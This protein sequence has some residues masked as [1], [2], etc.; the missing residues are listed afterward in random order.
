MAMS[1]LVL[2]EMACGM[3]K[4]P[5]GLLMVKKLL[6][7]IKMALFMA[8]GRGRIQMAEDISA[9]LMLVAGMEQES[10]F[11]PMAM[12]MTARLKM[13]KNTV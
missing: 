13:T 12:N 7:I 1:M 2:G 3:V 11:G 4:E 9:S 5:I 10:I 6:V 8:K